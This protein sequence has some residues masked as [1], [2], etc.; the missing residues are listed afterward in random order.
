MASPPPQG[1]Q[2]PPDINAP[3]ESQRA[4]ANGNREH[5]HEHDTRPNNLAIDQLQVSDASERQSADRPRTASGKDKTNPNGVQR[6]PSH[7]RI[8]GKCG[9]T[10]TG[11]FV[12]ALENTFHLECFTCN[13][14]CCVLQVEV[15]A[16][17]TWKPGLWQDRGFQILSS[18]REPSKSVSAL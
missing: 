2:L 18:T 9:G 14:S 13:V 16:W 7:T 1:A 5:L 17:L 15:E 10:L 11:Q 3:T 6:R 4:P 12:R 8:C